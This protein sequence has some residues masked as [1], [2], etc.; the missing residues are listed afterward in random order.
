MDRPS[1][2]RSIDLAAPVDRVWTELGDAD[3]L[4]GFLAGSAAPTPAD[5]GP[6][7]E[8]AALDLEIDGA[9]RRLVV[10]T[11]EAGHRLGFVWWDLKGPDLASTV[12][13]TVDA[14]EDG[15]RVTVTETLDPAALAL[16]GAGRASLSA[17]SIDIEASWDRRLDALVGALDRSLVAR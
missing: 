2:T 12:D 4:A 7:R 6:L 3:G 16:G 11:V 5:D 9:R 8:G 13:L 15:A 17:A 10:T 14:T 1:V